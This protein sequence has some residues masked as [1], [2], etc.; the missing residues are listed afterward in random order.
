MRRALAVV[1]VLLLAA[2]C[3]SG[4]GGTS[5]LKTD[6]GAQLRAAV[7]KTATQS[8]KLDVTIATTAGGQDVT[9]K[10]TG[11]FARDVGSMTLTIGT[12][13]V[14]ERLTGGKLYL[15]VPGQAKWYVLTLADLVGTS[16]A[17]SASPGD[18]AQVLLAVG[19]DVTKVGD[20]TVRGATATQYKGTIPITKERLA[21]QQGL[22]KAATR[23]LLDSGVTALPFNAWVDAQGRL[24]KLTEDIDLT[25][26]GTKAHVVTTL[27]RYDFGTKVSVVAPPAADQTDGGPIVDA[28]KQASGG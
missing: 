14:Q 2:G 19:N 23:K 15:K 9:V 17:D 20:D 25:I 28:L 1:P 11:A 5:T 7:T 21:A 22:V 24:V 26:K 13:S 6:L 10:G 8:S 27:E 16:L 12:V 3:G 4:G 18:A